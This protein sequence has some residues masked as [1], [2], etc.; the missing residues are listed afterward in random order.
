MPSINTI[1]HLVSGAKA[2]HVDDELGVDLDLVYLTDRLILMAWPGSGLEALYRNPRNDVRRFLEKRHGPRYRVYNLVPRYENSYESWEFYEQVS[3]FPFPDHH[4]PPLGMIPLFVA[5]VTAWLGEDERNVAVIH[6]KAGK[7]RTGTMSVAYLLSLPILPT[8]AASEKGVGTS[9]AAAVPQGISVDGGSKSCM[10]DLPPSSTAS[11]SDNEELSRENSGQNSSHGSSST[12]LTVPFS[13]SA[14]GSKEQQTSSSSA[15]EVASPIVSPVEDTAERLRTVLE[16]HTAR[17]LKPKSPAASPKGKQKAKGRSLENSSSLAPP[18]HEQSLIPPKDPTSLEKLDRPAFSG[19]R[20]RSTSR[21]GGLLRR[22]SFN[23][24]R[25]TASKD[26][27]PLPD[28]ELPDLSSESSTRQASAAA[29]QLFSPSALP[30]ACAPEQAAPSLHGTETASS[31]TPIKV[32]RSRKDLRALGVSPSGRSTDCLAGGTQFTNPF[33]LT[34]ADSLCSPS[35]GQGALHMSLPPTPP[36]SAKGSKPSITSSSHVVPP[37]TLAEATPQPSS[38]VELLASPSPATESR[39]AALQGSISDSNLSTDTARPQHDS[40]SS[41]R[42]SSAADRPHIVIPPRTSSTFARSDLDLAQLQSGMTSSASVG[43][44]VSIDS[45]DDDSEASDE[46]PRLAISIPSQRRFLGYWARMLA[47]SDPRSSIYSYTMRPT[48]RLVRITRIWIERATPS[49]PKASRPLI[50]ADNLSLQIM[51]YDP[52]LVDRLTDWERKARRRNKALGHSDPG[53]C[54]PELGWEESEDESEAPLSAEAKAAKKQRQEDRWRKVEAR[55]KARSALAQHGNI[56]GVGEWG[57]NVVAEATRARDFLWNDEGAQ[58][59]S[60][61]AKEASE[62]PS[63]MRRPTR[64]IQTCA[65]LSQ[66]LR[67][68]VAAGRVRYDFDPAPRPG[69]YFGMPAAPDMPTSPRRTS[70]TRLRGV[71]SQFNLSKRMRSGS[72]AKSGEVLQDEACADLVVDAD[73]ELGIK[74]PRSIGRIVFGHVRV[75]NASS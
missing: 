52:Q 27:P 29:S 33:A 10:R 42:R 36:R 63:R 56:A 43:N 67:E 68:R 46:A 49:D 58:H 48:K 66:S 61:A 75:F 40:E 7:G 16:L 35:D 51:R 54:A 2:R 12:H 6:C 23:F 11:R 13:G 32:V 65:M 34:S 71:S 64:Q 31:N 4:P 30:G 24:K 73:A 50:D 9:Q 44:L 22:A 5:D 19:T 26:S 8:L 55:N 47:N 60:A 37:I 57:I 20:S 1:R 53:A 21:V 69:S 45:D 17:R 70:P 28:G 3:R 25:S 41:I 15:S 38:A 18:M 62:P 59:L 72:N 14:R 74:Y 39:F